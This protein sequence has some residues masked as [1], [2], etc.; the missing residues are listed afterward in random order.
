MINWN[1]IINDSFDIQV[2]KEFVNKELSNRDIESLIPRIR[3]VVRER[4]V[5]ATRQLVK[6][7][8]RR[9]GITV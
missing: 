1:K 6:K 4:G 9:R 5:N 8:L 2:L 3:P 7:A